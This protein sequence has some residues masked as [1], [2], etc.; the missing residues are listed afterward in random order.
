LER[1]TLLDDTIFGSTAGWAVP[2][3]WVPELQRCVEGSTIDTCLPPRNDGYL[4]GTQ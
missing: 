3:D 4:L 2:F 1:I